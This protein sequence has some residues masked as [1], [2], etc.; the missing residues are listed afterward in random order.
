MIL[1]F[2]CFAQAAA[3][4]ECRIQLLAICF[5]EWNWTCEPCSTMTPWYVFVFCLNHAKKKHHNR[6]WFHHFY[7]CISLLIFIINNN[8]QLYIT[9]INQYK[10][11]KVWA[12]RRCLSLGTKPSSTGNLLGRHLSADEDSTPT[13]GNWTVASDNITGRPIQNPTESRNLKFMMIQ[14]HTQI[15]LNCLEILKH[16]ENYWIWSCCPFLKNLSSTGQFLAKTWPWR[17]AL[18]THLGDPKPTPGEF[19][20]P[21]KSCND[22]VMIA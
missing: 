19:K 22:S 1:L 7:L 16:I 8:I 14:L 10:S 12:W 9:I 18:Q 21:P 17:W 11:S 5:A 13:G 15:L 3:A 2:F 6:P 20:Q 4:A